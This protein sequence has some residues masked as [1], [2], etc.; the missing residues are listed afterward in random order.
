MYIHIAFIA[1]SIFP[2][3][4]LVRSDP[5]GVPREDMTAYHALSRVKWRLDYHVFPLIL[6]D[7]PIRETLAVDRFLQFVHKVTPGTNHS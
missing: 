3:A 4:S 5:K 7:N 1:N 6:L 2:T